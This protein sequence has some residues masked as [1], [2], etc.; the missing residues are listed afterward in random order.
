[1]AGELWILL[2]TA[3]CCFFVGAKTGSIHPIRI[4]MLLARVMADIRFLDGVEFGYF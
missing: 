4:M 3:T 1:M 2:Q